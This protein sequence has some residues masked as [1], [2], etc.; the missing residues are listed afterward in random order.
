[1]NLESSRSQFFTTILNNLSKLFRGPILAV[2]IVTYLDSEE[3]GYWYTIQG[4]I[5]FISLGDFGISKLMTYKVGNYLQEISNS[6]SYANK[7]LIYLHFINF[8][9]FSFNYLILSSIVVLILLLGLL[10][11][12]FKDWSAEY[13]KILNLSLVVSIFSLIT[14]YLTSIFYSSNLISKK[15]IQE[16]IFGLTYTVTSI[17][18]L[19]R[20]FKIETIYIAVLVANI[21]SVIP[22][23]KILKKWGFRIIQ[24]SKYESSLKMIDE[25]GKVL[26]KYFSVTLLSLYLT[27]TIT[28]FTLK[29]F[30]AEA[31]GKIGFSLYVITSINLF[32]WSF[33]YIEYPTIINLIALKK[34]A[35]AR[36]KG[37]IKLLS[38]ALAFIL[39]FLIFLNLIPQIS[40]F[41]P[42][43]S[44]RLVSNDQLILIFFNQLILL[45][46]GYIA[47]ISRGFQKEHFWKLSLIQ[48]PFLT[49]TF[50]LVARLENIDL[51][52]K[53]DLLLHLLIYLPVAYYISREEIKLL[54]G[55][56]IKHDISSK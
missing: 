12:V 52:F 31:A 56:V 27:N 8:L 25:Y 41:L 47:S 7:K 10:N 28:P 54:Y 1:M 45:I 9:R 21:I 22:Y 42:T 51:F 32:A 30:D 6:T 3:Q 55:K 26:L 20:G 39:G 17:F 44:S 19:Y 50:Y 33:F 16:I 18:L 11:L 53:I 46:I 34:F 23:Y 37:N 15:N 40:I 35:K 49:L 38:A 14:S 36:K 4:L 24:K 29:Y 2:F 43:F 48:V 13:L 5:V